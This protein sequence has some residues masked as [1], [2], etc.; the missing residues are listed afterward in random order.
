MTLV[1][2]F[3]MILLITSESVVG[4]VC[5]MEAFGRDQCNDYH[6]SVIVEHTRLMRDTAADIC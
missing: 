3:Y 1:I 4:T 5:T 6:K 2:H